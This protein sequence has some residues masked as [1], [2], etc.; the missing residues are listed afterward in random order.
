MVLPMAVILLLA[1]GSDYNLLFGVPVQG[2]TAGQVEDGIIRAMAGTGSVVTS[3]GLVFAFTMASFAFS[4][5]KVMA[6]VGTTIAARPAV[7]HADRAL[8]HDPRRGGTAR[9]VVLVAAEDPDRGVAAPAGASSAA[10][11]LPRL[12]DPSRQL[13]DQRRI[14]VCQQVTRVLEHLEAPASSSSAGETPP[15]CTPIGGTPARLAASQS[16]TESPRNTASFALT[17]ARSSATCTMSGLG[18]AVSTFPRT[19]PR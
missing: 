4:D 2:G 16:H 5:L 3:A 1:V 12:A 14:D 18:L 17:L 13:A 7:R 6:Q 15:L 9:P 10:I 8:V 11:R 19:S